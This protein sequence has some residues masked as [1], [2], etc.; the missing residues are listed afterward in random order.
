M[1]DNRGEAKCRTSGGDEPLLVFGVYRVVHRQCE[2]I[3]EDGRG[4]SKGDVVLE[5][6]YPLLV[7]VPLEFQF[8]DTPVSLT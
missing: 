7:F 5:R 1:D 2:R 6:V 8:H 3:A 4:L